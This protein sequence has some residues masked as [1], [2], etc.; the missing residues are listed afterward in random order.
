MLWESF[1]KDNYLK[2]I[3]V[4]LV[5]IDNYKSFS[6]EVGRSHNNL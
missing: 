5:G 6:G 3:I 4:K 1:D 2:T